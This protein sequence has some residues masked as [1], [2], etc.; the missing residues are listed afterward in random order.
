MAK[1]KYQDLIKQIEALSIK[2]Q[3][4]IAKK[5]IKQLQAPKHSPSML[6]EEDIS[7]FGSNEIV[8]PHCGSTH[9]IKKGYSNDGKIH[10]YLCKDC[11]KRFRRTTGSVLSNSKKDAEIWEKYI[12]LL[13]KGC[14]LEVCA[15]GAGISI[16]TAFAWR[17]KILA[18]MSM[19]QE[20]VVM[21]GI[22]EMDETFIPISYKGNHKHST[23]FTMPRKPYHRGS[24]NR[25]YTK[26][27]VLCALDRSGNNYAKMVCAGQLTAKLLDGIVP[28]I[29]D[30]NSIVIT[31]GSKAIGK[32]FKTSPIEHVTIVAKNNHKFPKKSV[33]HINNINNFHTRFKK[34]L[35]KYNGVA[36][37]YLNNYVG[38][39]LWLEAN[40]IAAKNSAAEAVSTVLQVGSYIPNKEFGTWARKP[41]LAPVA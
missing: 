26:A 28:K 40:R 20:N 15:K 32:F 23:T 34:Y 30:T 36:T 1:M 27:C 12:L 31:D 6:G 29:F 3:K 18:A 22:A 39:F 8:C 9:T 11:G 4:A 33:Y 21:S 2:E 13:L 41:A 7:D 5:L 17:H 25:E 19:G 14:T 10:R 35:L 16:P 37:K 38:L 24:D